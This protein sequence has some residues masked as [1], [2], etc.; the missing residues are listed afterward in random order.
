MSFITWFFVQVLT[1]EKHFLYQIL[2]EI[3]DANLCLHVATRYNPYHPWDWYVY[4]HE[5][6]I[7]YGKCRKYTSPMDVWVLIQIWTS[8]GWF[9]RKECQNLSDRWDLK[10][11][12]WNQH[13]TNG[14]WHNVDGNV[15]TNFDRTSVEEWNCTSPAD[16]LYSH[17]IDSFLRLFLW[18]VLTDFKILRRCGRRQEWWRGT[19]LVG[20]SNQLKTTWW[21]SSPRMAWPWKQTLKPPAIDNPEKVWTSMMLS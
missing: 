11:S 18:P 20:K 19:Q 15:C 5:W 1:K 10:N 13:A 17:H 3:K 12:T 7:F 9:L 2:S 16:H 21:T 4:L 14:H 6:L 8:L